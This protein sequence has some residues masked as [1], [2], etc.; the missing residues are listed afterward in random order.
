MGFYNRFYAIRWQNV[1]RLLFLCKGNICRSAY[2][3]ARARSLGL[4]AISRGLDVGHGLG[5]TPK[6]IVELAASRGL[7]FS[8]HR[9][10]QFLESDI[11]PGDLVIAM[12][13]AQA[14]KV[15][16]QA[17][18]AGAQVTLLGLWHSEPRPYLQD[19]F[20][21]SK[22]YTEYCME[23]MDAAAERLK[24]LLESNGHGE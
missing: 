13:P 7:D 19:P 15:E 1:R 4:S 11:L 9:P 12:E 22:Q 14:E 6:T 17:K 18:R 21:M 23:F 20:G 5:S 10:T 2:C 16:Q 24:L 8:C 3:E